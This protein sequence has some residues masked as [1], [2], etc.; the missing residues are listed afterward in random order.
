MERTSKVD[1]ISADEFKS[2]ISNSESIAEVLGKLGYQNKSGTMH[3]KVK[4]RIKEDGLNTEHMN[5]LNNSLIKNG[6]TKI[7]LDEILIENSTYT[8]R[9]RLKIRIVNEKILVYK[10]VECGNKGEWAGKPLTLH[11]DHINGINND[12]RVKNIRFL[13]PNCHSQ[14]ETYSGKNYGKYI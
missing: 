9:T 3:N 1:M 5:K 11:L 2:L 6:V 8:N 12:N 4:K 7:P 10:C 13:C 14:T